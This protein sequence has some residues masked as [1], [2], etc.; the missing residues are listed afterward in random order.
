MVH[1]RYGFLCVPVDRR[2]R[3]WLLIPPALGV[4]RIRGRF[5][6][7]RSHLFVV[8]SPSRTDPSPRVRRQSFRFPTA[9]SNVGVS[10]LPFLMW[11]AARW[12]CF[13]DVL[14]RLLIRGRARVH[15]SGD[16]A[17]GSALRAP[18]LQEW[19]QHG[20]CALTPLCEAAFTHSNVF[21]ID[22]HRCTYWESVPSFAEGC[23]AL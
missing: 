7:M 20:L 10:C 3:Q 8:E 12:P 18:R 23:S 9:S 22:L 15:V 4:A 11:T 2:R 16:G 6:R 21:D 1:R 19:C 13:Y 14:K 5:P 17:Q